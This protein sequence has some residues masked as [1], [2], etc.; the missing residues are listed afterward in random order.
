MVKEENDPPKSQSSNE[1]NMIVLWNSLRKCGKGEKSPKKR[2]VSSR[3][4]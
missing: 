2:F 3:K 4:L 1:D